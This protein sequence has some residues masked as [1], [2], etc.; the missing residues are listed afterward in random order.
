[1]SVLANTSD[2]ED[3]ENP[4]K[5][6]KK[7]DDFVRESNAPLYDIEHNTGREETQASETTDEHSKDSS[8]HKKRKASLS[9]EISVGNPVKVGD[10]TNAH[11]VYSIESRNLQLNPSEIAQNNRFAVTRRYRDFC[12]VYKQLQLSHPGR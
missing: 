10:I 7:A 12:W 4:T 6:S 8:N 9:T 3:A 5:R 11:I 1:M 2:G